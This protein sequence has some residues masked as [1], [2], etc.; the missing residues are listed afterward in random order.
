[1]A[2]ILVVDDSSFQRGF[3][4][5]VVEK[6]GYKVLEAENGSEALKI[7]HRENPDCILMDLIMPEVGGIE[8]LN[9]L[10]AQK[11]EIPVIVITADIQGSIHQECLDLGAV[12]VL[13]KPPNETEILR[14]IEKTLF[15]REEVKK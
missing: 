8:V 2:L 6:E 13:N 5:R 1:M 12:A 11:S 7:L 10:R 15:S 4:R 9:Q 14:T 3:I